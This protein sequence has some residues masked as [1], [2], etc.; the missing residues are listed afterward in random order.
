MGIF[1]LNNSGVRKDIHDKDVKVPGLILNINPLILPCIFSVFLRY[2]PSISGC[3]SSAEFKLNF[4]FKI[5]CKIRRKKKPKNPMETYMKENSG[6]FR[7]NYI[8]NHGE[9]FFN[10]FC[11]SFNSIASQPRPVSLQNVHA[12]LPNSGKIFI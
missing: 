12:F 3:K 10:M 11:S 6:K 2:F 5:Q 1:F 7:A 9:N 8:G 4:Q